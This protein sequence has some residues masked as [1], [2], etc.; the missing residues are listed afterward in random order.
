MRNDYYSQHD[1]VNTILAI[2]PFDDNSCLSVEELNE[3]LIEMNMKS[4]ENSSWL[5]N[6]YYES[7][8]RWL[9]KVLPM[10]MNGLNE[11]WRRVCGLTDKGEEVHQ[12]TEMVFSK[13]S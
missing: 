4:I 2:Y 5:E 10:T 13:A 12:K 6:Y 8:N 9:E 1:W 7:K 11:E 3:A